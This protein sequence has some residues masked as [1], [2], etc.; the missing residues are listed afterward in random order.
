MPP[1]VTDV[2]EG[3]QLASPRR[4]ASLINQ[5]LRVFA[6][7][8][9]NEPSFMVTSPKFTYDKSKAV[10]RTASDPTHHLHLISFEQASKVQFEAIKKAKGYKY[11]WDSSQIKT[12]HVIEV[13]HIIMMVMCA[14]H[15]TESNWASLPLTMTVHLAFYLSNRRNLWRIPKGLG[16]VKSGIPL[17]CWYGSGRPPYIK[18]HIP[19]ANEI[20]AFNLQSNLAKQYLFAYTNQ[21]GQTPFC[22]LLDLAAE[23]S[24]LP[25]DSMTW[26][27][28]LAGKELYHL[29]ESWSGQV[30]GLDRNNMAQIRALSV[31]KEALQKQG[32]I[33]P[34]HQRLGL[35]KQETLKRHTEKS[36]MLL[37][38][39]VD[40][41]AQ[42]MNDGKGIQTD[43]IPRAQKEAQ[44]SQDSDDGDD[45]T[46]IESSDL[47]TIEDFGELNS[48]V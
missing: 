34:E 16:L 45:P 12:S 40:R 2:P 42:C 22:S 14:G 27:T 7:P 48:T 23:M 13:Q 5:M 39:D 41:T 35:D 20:N 1:K 47:M 46:F 6:L 9:G 36:L 19:Q 8:H 26:V 32:K 4:I 10:Y 29:L 31:Q 11:T 24:G 25:F 3:E 44:T 28:V 43:L 38:G 18:G 21:D 37:T 33:L 17:S 30:D 15:L